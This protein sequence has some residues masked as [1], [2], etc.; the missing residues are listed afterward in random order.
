KGEGRGSSL[1]PNI[2]NGVELPAMPTIR[3]S[4]VRA[5]ERGGWREGPNEARKT[6]PSVMHPLKPLPP[7]EFQRYVLENSGQMLPLFGSGFFSQPQG[8]FDP[9][10][11]VPVSPDYRIG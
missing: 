4:E 11:N 8:A 5:D 10:G 1:S 7:N 3:Q 2:G 6:P 9:Q